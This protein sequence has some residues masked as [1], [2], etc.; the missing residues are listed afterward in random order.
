MPDVIVYFGPLEFI[1]ILAGIFVVSVL[2]AAFVHGRLRSAEHQHLLDGFPYPA[3]LF[4]KFHQP[5]SNGTAG[6]WIDSMEIKALVNDAQTRKQNILRTIPDVEGQSYQVRVIWLSRGSTLVLLEDMG[7][8]QRQQAFYRNFINNVSHELKTPLTV[9]QGHAANMGET[10]QDKEG[11]RTSLRIIRDEAKRLTQL[12]DNLLTLARL[13]SPSFTLETKPTSFTALLEE[14]ILQI[15]D[16]AEERRLAI[17]L[18][19]P[20]GLPNINADRPRLKQVLLNLL[21]NAIKYT[22][23]GGE[24]SLGLRLDDTNDEFICV[25]QDSGEGIPEEDLPYI[26]DTLYRAQ[27]SKGRPVEGSGLGLSIAKQIIQAHG[28]EIE[29]QSKLGQGSIFTFTLP[30]RDAYEPPETAEPRAKRRDEK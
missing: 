10:P 23:P 16:L 3:I 21:D 24:I 19:V 30:Y 2:I 26:F 12:V 18:N 17:R 20:P 15:S 9:I 5:R 28:G 25:V 1:A 13:E 7:A 29:V 4:R 8:A 6:R 27:R 22:E 14:S 11:W